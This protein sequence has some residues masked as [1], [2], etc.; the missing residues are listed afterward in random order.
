MSK[1]GIGVLG[2]IVLRLNM[3]NSFLF[4]LFLKE[5][6]GKGGGGGGANPPNKGVFFVSHQNF[7]PY[8]S[9]F[10]LTTSVTTSVTTSD[11]LGIY[12]YLHSKEINTGQGQLHGLSRSDRWG[13][14]RRGVNILLSGPAVL[15]VNLSPE[16]GVYKIL[17]R[18]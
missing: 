1:C 6:V 16:T 5:R 3:F 10:T 9:P 17:T 18:S 11:I 13:S 12:W 7:P 4:L 15:L 14:C 2:Y 8:Q